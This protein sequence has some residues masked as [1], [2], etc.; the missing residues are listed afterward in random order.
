MHTCAA[1]HSEAAGGAAPLKLRRRRG[2]G[3]LETQAGVA[4]NLAG[5]LVPAGIDVLHMHM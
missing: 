1:A 5:L 4:S 3:G 2:D